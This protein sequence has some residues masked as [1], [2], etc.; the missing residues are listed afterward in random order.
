MLVSSPIALYL[1]LN[2]GLPTIRTAVQGASC[3]CL[4]GP[5]T[6]GAH[7]CTHLLLLLFNMVTGFLNSDAHAYTLS[8]LPNE[9]S[10]KPWVTG[11]K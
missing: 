2:L 7:P 6:A 8:I 4:A 10:S 1:F 11:I 9:P 3:L 5:A